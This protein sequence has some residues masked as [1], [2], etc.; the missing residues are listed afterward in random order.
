MSSMPNHQKVVLVGDGAVGSSYAF[1]MAQ[2]GIAEEFAVNPT[3]LSARFREITG[4]NFIKYLTNRRMEEA[5]LLLAKGYK[6]SKTCEAVGYS[7][8]RYFC[9][10]FKKQTGLTPA[11][12]RATTAAEAGF[13]EEEAHE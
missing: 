7:N 11:E 9:D 12:Y 5:K 8:Y 1:A 2:Q 6:V 4:T 10:V 3:Y 13:D